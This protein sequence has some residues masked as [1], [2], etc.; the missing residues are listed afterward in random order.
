MVKTDLLGPSMKKTAFI[1][2]VTGQD[3]SY[4]AQLLL[5]K[6][7]EVHGL[8]RW[9]CVDGTQRLKALGISEQLTLHDGEMSDA[10]SLAHLLKAIRPDEVYNLA[11]LSHVKTS[12]ATPAAALEV[13]AKGTLNLLEALRVLGMEASVRLYQA[14]SSE[15]FGDAPAP[16]NEHTPMQPCSPYGVSKLAAYWLVRNYREAYGIFAANG[17]LFNHESPLRGEDFVTQKIV[18]AVAD[19]EAGARTDLTLGNLD[20]KRDWGHAKDYVRGMW[21]MLQADCADD[22]VLASGV[23]RTV[24]E[25]AEAAF[26][27]AGMHLRWEGSG[28][29]ET[30]VC[31]KSGKVL[32]RIDPS[33]YRPKEVPHLLGDASKAKTQLG[34]QPELGFDI[35]VAD[36][37]REARSHSFSAEVPQWRKTG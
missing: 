29:D 24:R 33:F 22:F 37:M 20:A 28:G 17:I 7:Y 5:G 10:Q 6:G 30:G 2:G 15:M 19:I 35:L 3:G 27:Y 25:F 16:Q 14:S 34:W 12:F 21:M 32:V 36:M 13:N 18:R 31:V 1:T 8:V 11:A 4:L 9:D 23:A 26:A